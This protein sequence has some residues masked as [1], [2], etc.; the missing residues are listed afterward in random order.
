MT[1]MSY[2]LVLLSC[3][4][5]LASLVLVLKNGSKRIPMKK[6]KETKVRNLM[7]GGFL[8]LDARRLL[9]TLAH[10]L[11]SIHLGMFEIPWC[12]QVVKSWCGRLSH[13]WQRYPKIMIGIC[14]FVIIFI[15]FIR[16]FYTCSL[17][18]T[19]S[20][21]WNNS[22]KTSN[23]CMALMK[24]ARLEHSRASRNLP[25]CWGPASTDSGCDTPHFTP[26]SAD[27]FLVGKHQWV[28]GYTHHF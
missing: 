27:D 7:L 2:A 24:P 13:Y 1:H 18:F 17:R 26:P 3:C 23:A 14:D 28:V 21:D 8:R 25:R 5:S 16:S 4:I 20:L 12:P 22:D 11:R 19:I 9:I 15:L 6:F 10:W